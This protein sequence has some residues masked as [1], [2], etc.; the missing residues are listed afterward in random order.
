LADVFSLEDRTAI[1]ELIANYAYMWDGKDV[2][3]FGALFT[4]DAVME[5]YYNGESTPVRRGETR[6]RIRSVAVE[7]FAGRLEG[8]QTRHH[9]NSTVLIEVHTD[10]ARGKTMFLVTHQRADEATPRLMVSGVYQDTFVKT[11]DGW[12]FGRRELHLTGQRPP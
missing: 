1:L 9:Q 2:D 12:R 3:G 4:E 8:V 10:W 5:R 6:A 7:S 11:A